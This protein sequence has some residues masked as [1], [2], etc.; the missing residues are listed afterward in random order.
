MRPLT[1]IA[2]VLV[3]TV[4]FPIAGISKVV[5]DSAQD[6]VQSSSTPSPNPASV[7]ESAQRALAAGDYKSAESGFQEVLK[8]DPQSA[9]AYINLGVVYMRTEKLDAAIE[10]L[11]SAKKLAP[12]MVGIDLNL[13]LAYYRRKEFSQAIPYFATVLSADPHNLQARY[14]KGMCHFAMDDYG[15]VVETLEPIAPDQKDDLGFLFALAISYG[16]INHEEESKKTFAQLVR[17]GGDSANMHLLLGK[18]YLDQRENDKARVELEKALTSDPKMPFAHFNLGV[19]YQRL[20]KLDQAAAEF[21][22]EMAITPD[23]PWSYENRGT[24]YL[25]QGDVDHAIAMFEKA[26]ALNPRMTLSL[27]GLGKA[28]IQK[29]K[30]EEAIPYL[31]RAV[32]LQADNASLHYQLAQAYLKAGRREEGGKELAET[33]RLQAEFRQS[34]DTEISGRLPQSQGPQQ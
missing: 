24:I 19:S 11:E 13:G 6:T 22:Q 34:Q 16:K 20:G 18:A 26:L 25:D 14:L 3:G 27:A 17:A 23:E 21:E 10:A 5:S 32:A 9:A 7:F 31:Q 29:S 28:Y 2:I 1:Y 12:D 33:K 4:I 8:L 15:A 30:P